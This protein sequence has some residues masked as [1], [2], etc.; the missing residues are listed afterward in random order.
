MNEAADRTALL[1]DLGELVPA[2]SATALCELRREAVLSAIAER[3]AREEHREQRRGAVHAAGGVAVLVACVAALASLALLA[4]TPTPRSTV[5][6]PRPVVAELAAVRVLDRMATVAVAS[7]SAA[8]GADQFVYVRSAVIG[9]SAHLGAGVR[10]GAPHQR[11]IWLSQDSDAVVETGLLREF[12]Q[13]WPVHAGAPTPPG[14]ARPTYGWLA[15]LPSD[16]DALLAALESRLPVE[17]QQSDQALFVAIGGLV[18][19]SV[20]PPGTAAALF[21]AVARIPGVELER[22]VE[23]ALGRRGVGIARTDE[24]FG[25]R[26]VW[27]VDADTFDLLGSRDY[28][29]PGEGP[30]VLYGATAVLERAVVDRA[31]VAPDEESRPTA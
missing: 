6:A 10:L 9:N 1:A 28:L 12:G 21:E 27:V 4:V 16:P 26:S 13:D 8:V 3:L 18:R 23:D 7:E 19:E 15:G 2:P 30:D 17:Q 22:D 14:P 25:T 20:L 11:E 24:R 31:G 5:V 29:S